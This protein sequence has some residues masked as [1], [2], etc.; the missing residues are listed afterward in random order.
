V[1]SFEEY[2]ALAR[3]LHDLH[4]TAEA[5][6]AEASGRR[7]R[8]T[9][10]ADQLGQRLYAQWQRLAAIAQATNEPAPPVPPPMVVAW[11]QAPAGSGNSDLPPP[12]ARW[13]GL[14]PPPGPPGLPPPRR[15]GLLPPPR[16]PESNTDRD[17][18]ALPTSVAGAP[19]P[20]P[21]PPQPFPPPSQV[22]PGEA[23]PGQAPWGRV[24]PDPE[25][26]LILTRQQADETDAAASRAE[27]LAGQPPLLPTWSPFGRAVAVYLGFAA[28]VALLQFVLLM[29]P[30][31]RD[32][33]TG[34]QFAWICAGFPT[35]AFFSAYIVLSIWGKA[36]LDVDGPARYPRLGFLLCY[37]AAP[38][39]MLGFIMLNLI[40]P[41]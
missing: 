2:A 39:S 10:I 20:L 40:S 22:P 36:R 33:D 16:R 18:A 24:P 4:R 37:A 26:E 21:L 15:P 3:H 32:A 5:G 31:A 19:P 38:V 34:T 27:T 7:Q 8:L 41:F 25:R 9:A 35:I 12:P 14:P 17:L 1:T 29:H 28:L 11:A 6:S 13:P 30:L 23:Q